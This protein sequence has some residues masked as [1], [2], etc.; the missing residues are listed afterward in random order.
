MSI[1]ISRDR[2]LELLD[3]ERKLQALEAGGVDNWD[4]YSDSL[5]EH[6][7]EPS[8]EDVDKEALK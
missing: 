8:M 7:T 2:L 4:W 1:T 3:S 6:Y 5:E